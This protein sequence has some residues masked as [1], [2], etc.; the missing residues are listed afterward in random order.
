M[1]RAT[2]TYD[3]LLEAGEREL[4]RLVRQPPADERAVLLGLEPEGQVRERGPGLG[5]LHLAESVTPWPA[6]AP[7][8]RC[9]HRAGGE[10]GVSG[11]GTSGVRVGGAE[12][13]GYDL[14]RGLGDGGRGWNIIGGAASP[15]VPGRPRTAAVLE[16]PKRL[17]DVS[18]SAS[19]RSPT[20]PRGAR[21]SRPRTFGSVIFPRMQ[22][23]ATPLSRF[24]ALLVARVI[25]AAPSRA[26]GRRGLAL[27][28]RPTS[29]EGH[30]TN[31]AL[32]R[33]RRAPPAV[34]RQVCSRSPRT[35]RVAPTG[36]CG[37]R[38]NVRSRA[39]TRAA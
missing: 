8:G 16:R 1:D 5:V 6:T 34:A 32:D 30:W 9:G 20:F 2:S 36:G 26:P 35:S 28:S 31:S 4:A 37:S 17:A 23:A 3:A 38:R 10:A 11:H 15:P 21:L 18:V 39:A 29:R 25:I 12:K 27:A 13:H 7:T 22:S 19:P 24:L 14:R 33:G